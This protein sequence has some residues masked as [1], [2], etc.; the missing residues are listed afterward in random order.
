MFRFSNFF[1]QVRG[2]DVEFV[3]VLLTRIQHP[4]DENSI[5]AAK[6]AFEKSIYNA[7]VGTMEIYF[8]WKNWS[9]LSIYPNSSFT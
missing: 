7:L 3:F 9:I 1:L 6:Y 8:I 2:L 4:P 5:I